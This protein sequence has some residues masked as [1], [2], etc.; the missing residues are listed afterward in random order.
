MNLISDVGGDW[1]VVI[2][3]NFYKEVMNITSYFLK[4]GDYM[5]GGI[6]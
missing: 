4:N 3:S 6:D 1:G 2:N 5:H